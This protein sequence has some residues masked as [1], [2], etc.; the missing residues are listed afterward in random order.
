M[1]KLKI[2]Q[3]GSS[4]TDSGGIPKHLVRL[5]RGLV[6]KGHEVHVT[7]APGTWV[8]EQATAM[9]LPVH[10]IKVAR[11]QDWSAFAPYVR[12]LRRERFDIMHVQFARDFI[13][14]AVAAKISGQRGLLMTRHLAFPWRGI[15][16]RLY[17][18]LLYA[19]IIAVS[20]AVKCALEL[21]GIATS[22]LRTVHVGVETDDGSHSPADLRSELNL[23]TDSVLIGIVA[24]ISHE[25]GHEQLIEAM[26]TVDASAV[27][28]VIGDGPEAPR[29]RAMA[30]NDELAGRVR[31]LGF[32]ENVPSVMAA[33]DIM[34]QPS[35]WP[36]ACSASILEAMAMG[37]PVVATHVGGNPELIEHNITGLLTPRNDPAALAEALNTLIRDP[38]M[39]ARAGDAGRARQQAHFTIEAMTDGVEQVYHN[40]LN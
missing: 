9:G 4:M 37:T 26:R 25:K 14:P 19:R 38:A 34:A 6:A 5:S 29:F 39:R 36:E 3:V 35:T 2:L 17:G 7:C 1:R 30:E 11:Q 20:G 12:L 18:Q 33:L 22:R 16:R 21:G 8:W 31:F 24:R 40:L 15:H 13:V 32:R 28:L 27:C 23:R 10:S